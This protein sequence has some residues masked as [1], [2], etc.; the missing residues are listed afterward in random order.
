M[1]ILQYGSSGTLVPLTKVTEQSQTT[2]NREGALAEAIDRSFRSSA[3]FIGAFIARLAFWR[4][5]KNKK[6]DQML[7]DSFNASYPGWVK[8]GWVKKPD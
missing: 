4:I 5:P 6:N 2:K 1:T 8:K 3:A 7:M